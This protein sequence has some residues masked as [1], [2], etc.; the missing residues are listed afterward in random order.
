MK[1]VIQWQRDIKSPGNINEFKASRKP[2]PLKP[3][4]PW[5]EKGQ[6]SE[7]AT[8]ERDSWG[9]EILIQLNQ[10]LNISK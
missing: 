2:N 5:I 10:S 7:L 6:H 3:W 1:K 4:L 9:E 8:H